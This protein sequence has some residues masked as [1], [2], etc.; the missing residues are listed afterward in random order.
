MGFSLFCSPTLTFTC[1]QMLF[2]KNYFLIFI[3]FYDYSCL[4][5]CISVHYA[6]AWCH[7]RSEEGVRFSVTGVKDVCESPCGCREL[8]LD[9]PQ[10]VC[11]KLL[12]HLFS[13]YEKFSTQYFLVIQ[14]HS[15][16]WNV[17]VLLSWLICSLGLPLLF[18]LES[19]ASE[20]GGRGFI[21][22][23][24]ILYTTVLLKV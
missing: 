22:L 17:W 2:W 13:F 23:T 9:L 4:P 21:M 12:S 11:F 15:G 14:E 1:S 3:L 7:C 5:A 20:L 19:S 8:N 10:G 6:W 16:I 24:H 18:M